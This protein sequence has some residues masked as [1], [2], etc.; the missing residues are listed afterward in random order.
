MCFSCGKSVSCTGLETTVRACGRRRHRSRGRH[1]LAV[2]EIPGKARKRIGW[3]AILSQC[4]WSGAC[5]RSHETQ[6]EELV[7]QEI[8]IG[9]TR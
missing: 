7:R 4:G 2:S 3:N 1:T 6:I 9:E 8:L 5:P